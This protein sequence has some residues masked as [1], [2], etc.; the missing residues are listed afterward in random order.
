MTWDF[1]DLPKV[2]GVGFMLRQAQLYKCMYAMKYEVGV[3]TGV[4]HEDG[5]TVVAPALLEHEA[6]Q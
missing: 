1:I 6:K 5:R 4:A 2:V 3:F